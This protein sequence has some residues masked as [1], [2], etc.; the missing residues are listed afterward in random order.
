MVNSIKQ[1]LPFIF[2]LL[3]GVGIFCLYFFLKEQ[4]MKDAIDACSVSC[5]SLIGIG[6]LVIITRLGA[7]DT[8]IFGFKQ[9]VTS[10]FSKDPNVYNSMADYKLAKYDERKKKKMTYLMFFLAGFIFLI[11]LIVL[12]II[13]H[14][15]YR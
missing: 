13:F 7:F 1:I 3:F 2:S 5:V 8:F 15:F 10:M 12:E 9:M 14:I 11:G 4:T 6:L